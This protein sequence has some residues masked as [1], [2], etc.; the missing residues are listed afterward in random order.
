MVIAQEFI[1]ILS[2]NIRHSTEHV[3]LRAVTEYDAVHQVHYSCYFG[4]I[5]LQVT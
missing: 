5:N 4:D 1:S 3:T 2:F